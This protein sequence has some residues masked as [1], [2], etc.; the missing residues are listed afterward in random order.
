MAVTTL[1]A[2]DRRQW[3]QELKEAGRSLWKLTEPYG[4][5]ENLTESHGT[6]TTYNARGILCN[7]RERNMTETDGTY[8]N[9]TEERKEH[10]RT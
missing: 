8:R 5:L 2:Y 7:R 6:N 4:M 10:E 3:G 1:D 9:A